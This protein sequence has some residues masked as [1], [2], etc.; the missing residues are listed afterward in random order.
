MAEATAFRLLPLELWAAF[1]RGSAVVDARASLDS[2]W[3]SYSREGWIRFT[4]PTNKLSGEDPDGSS[5][6]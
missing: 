2:S 3:V 5:P 6:E 1:R 4:P